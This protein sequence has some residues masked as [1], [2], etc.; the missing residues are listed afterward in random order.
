[1]LAMSKRLVDFH[2]TARI[3]F[4]TQIA[5]LKHML[6]TPAGLTLDDLRPLFQEHET[7]LKAGNQTLV[8]DLLQWVGFL[9][10]QHLVAYENARY[11]ITPAGRDFLTFLGTI[12][13]NEAKLF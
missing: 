5:A 12:G 3:V 8:P 13:V 11:K 10:G 2:V 1:M 7:R 9:T 4:G 6:G